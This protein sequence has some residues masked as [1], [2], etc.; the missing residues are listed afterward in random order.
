M[1]NI[2]IRFT[3]K[4]PPNIVSKAIALLGGSPWVSHCFVIVDGIAYEATMGRGCRAVPVSVAMRG[5]KSYQDMFLKVQ[6]K[7]RMIEWGLLQCGKGY[8]WAGAL[9]IPFV[10]SADWQNDRRWW[11][12]EHALR[13]IAEGGKW[14]LDPATHKRVT[15]EML[16]SLPFPKSKVFYV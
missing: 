5:V 3:T 8:D 1:S 14:I 2:T 10:Q 13:M 15:P 9:G 12:S 6:L 4:W 16:R 11:C 7:G